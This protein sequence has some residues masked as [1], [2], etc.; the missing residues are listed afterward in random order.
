VRP[1]KIYLNGCEYA[2]TW[3]IKLELFWRTLYATTAHE[4]SHKFKATLAAADAYCTAVALREQT[5]ASVSFQRQAASLPPTQN[6]DSAVTPLLAAVQFG[7]SIAQIA[8][9]AT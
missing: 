1:C 6:V 8:T 2:L 4:P 3:D 5:A 9:N 7:G